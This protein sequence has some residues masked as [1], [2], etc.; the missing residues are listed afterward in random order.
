MDPNAT[1]ETIRR[2]TKAILDGDGNAEELAEELAEACEALDGWL[3]R[4]GFL[5]DAWHQATPTKEG[6]ACGGEGC[7]RCFG[8]P[9]HTDALEAMRAALPEAAAELQ[10]AWKG[11]CIGCGAPIPA[12]DQWCA[13]CIARNSPR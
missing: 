10:R 11:R 4:G 8:E 2:L 13:A 12:T 6:C 5:P 1:L 3:T 9:S 7:F